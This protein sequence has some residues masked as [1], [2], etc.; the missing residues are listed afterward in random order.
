MVTSRFTLMSH[1]AAERIAVPLHA[2]DKEGV[3]RE[4]ADLTARSVGEADR[5]DELAEAVLERERVLSTGIGG[6][7]ALPHARTAVVPSLALAAGT[8]PDG[9]EFAALD[10]RPVRLIFLLAGPVDTAGDHV[11][12]LSRLS[13]L[14]AEEELRERLLACGGPE[15]FLEVVREAEAA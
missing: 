6:G 4:L 11:R 1:L 9:V 3:I 12:A 15:E 5:T 10:G 7:V 14:L 8:S 13:R 2:D